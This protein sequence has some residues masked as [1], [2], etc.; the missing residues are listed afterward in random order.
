MMVKQCVSKVQKILEVPITYKARLK[1]EGKKMS[2]WKAMKM[3]CGIFQCR[4]GGKKNQ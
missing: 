3:Y 4:M 2:W 1:R